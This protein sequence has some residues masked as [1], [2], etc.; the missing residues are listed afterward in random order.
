MIKTLAGYTSIPDLEK[1]YKRSGK[2]DY[3]KCKAACCRFAIVGWIE[4]EEQGK[5]FK[6]MGFKIVV[7]NG[8]IAIFHD[9][10]CE[11]LDLKTFKCKKQNRKSVA[12]KQFPMST[13]AVY[14]KVASKCSYKFKEGKQIKMA[15]K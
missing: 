2:C 8:R 12:C 3:K 4:D 11:Q 1:N 13:D 6:D 9:K 10:P 15:P 5:Y 14:Q 7:I